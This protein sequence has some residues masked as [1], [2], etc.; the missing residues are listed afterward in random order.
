MSPILFPEAFEAA[1]AE[2]R[3]E[4]DAIVSN[5]DEPTFDN[6]LVAMERA[7]RTLDRVER[8]F[9]VARE[10]VTNREYQ[11]LEREWQPRLAAAADEIVFNAGLFRKIEKV[12]E[13]LAESALEPD[14]VR[15]TTRIYEYF[16]RRG[17]KLSPPQKR[18]LSE[19][20]QELAARFAEFRAKV[21]ADENTWTV[22]E[23]QADLDG[24]PASVIAAAKRAA[25]ERGLTGKW[26]IVNTRSSV[27]PFLTFSTRRGLRETVWKKFKSRGDNGDANDTKTTITAIV[28]LRA[29]RARLLGFD[30][31]AHWRM[32][33]TMAVDPATAQ[34]F[35]LEVWPFVTA[36]VRQE[37]ADMQQLAGGITIEPWDYLCFAEKVRKAKYDL[38]E[39]EI[40][41]YLQL[42]NMVAAAL[43][44]AERRFAIEFREITGTVPVF[45]PEMR[46]WEV[47]DKPTG[48]HR[49]VF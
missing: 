1:I 27:D 40:K 9:G 21:L 48:Q 34:A 37:V 29:E 13:S 23:H 47:T 19:I 7:G 3:M 12:Y 36:R 2:Q 22:I 8:M 20:N 49:A 41:P 33:D 35:L 5:P 38:D 6:T 26:A 44:S 42:D 16:V 10:N 25:D 28:N 4:I 11:A 32:Q 31:H 39:A 30:S 18:R 24:L 15:L 45:H 14:Q 17:A 43:W 46:V